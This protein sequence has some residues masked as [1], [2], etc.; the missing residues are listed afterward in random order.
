MQER[1]ITSGK[2]LLRQL[3]P[4]LARWFAATFR[5]FTDA[6][7][8]CIPWI[9][10][11]ESILLT[12]P[13]GSGKTLAA[14]LGIFDDLLRKIEG[15]TLSLGVHC[16]YVSPLRAL[17][18][19]IGK[20]L[21]A[22]IAGMNLETELRIHVRTGDTSAGERAK[23]RRRPSHFLLTTPESL[24][25]LL[26]QESYAAHLS[27]C[28]FVIVDELH[29]FAG[30]KRGVD[31]ALS[32]ERLE[33]LCRR[34]PVEGARVVPVEKGTSP[35]DS[36]TPISRF[37]Q[38]SV[39]RRERSRLCRV[40]LSATAAPL[41]LLA[42]F[43]AGD[44]RPC[45]IARAR[46]EK[47]SIVEVFSPI[48]RQPYP[49]AGYT[50]V[51]LYAEL[52]NLIRSRQ[53]VL[54]FTNV[55]S[56]AEQIGLRLKE[57]LPE[58]ADQIE[59]HHASLDRSVRLEVEDRLKN[60]EL[61]AVVCSTSLELG[62]DIGAVDLVVMVATP[63]GVSR[64][65]QRIGRSGHSLNQNSHGVLVA[66]N[67]ND[68]VEA[69]AT[70]YLVRQGALDPVKVMEKPND[71]L[72]QHI[73]GMAALAPIAVETAFALVRRAFPYRA[74]EHTEFERVLE[75]LVGGGESLRRQYSNLFG[76]IVVA[77][78]IISLAHPG[79]AREF[80]LNIGTIVS[81]GFVSVLLGRRRLG[82]VEEGF[83]KQLQLGDLFVLAGRV[84]R[85]IDT[86]VQ[87]V[88][89]ERADGQLPTIPR[90]NAAKMPLTSGLAK[91]VRKLRADLARRL[92]E[93]SDAAA[94]DWLVETYQISIANAQPIVEFFRAQMAI[95]EV[96]VGR[97]LLIEL[98]RE[99]EHSHY[100][101]HSLI[102]RS[103]NDALSRILA[104]RV[105]ERIG[106][107]ALV[108]IDDYG[109]LLTLRRFQELPLGQ[110]RDCFRRAEAEEDLRAALRGS[111]LVKWQ[112]RGVAQTGL[113]VPRNL[114]GRERKPRQLSWSSEVL[115]R[116]LEQHEPDHPLL[117][118][119]YR[120]ATHTFLDAEIA[121]AFLDEVPAF[122]WKLRELPVVSPFSFPIYASK[123]KE[124]M[125][126]EDPA[127]AI[128]RIYF[129]MYSRVEQA[130]KTRAPARNRREGLEDR[131]TRRRRRR[132]G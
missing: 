104:W 124:S 100:F 10:K 22:P 75:Y 132:R 17:T 94:I 58:L 118:E 11:R 117:E 108:T 99:S 69:I 31:L 119:A 13:T 51:R 125:M 107:N 115:F 109:F 14:F 25:V 129:E 54:V 38:R 44:D 82:S 131:M 85:L 88:H 110:W 53:S 3:H 74:L 23:F 59:T 12:S 102:G 50:G 76:K 26:A 112:F 35:K 78:G 126:L 60:G 40:G 70:A 130:T 91:A 65:V 37:A 28:R 120:Q 33:E 52:A 30:N 79:I 39:H 113:M 32:L 49:P 27:S 16:L 29:S 4:R 7:L 71:V 6:Q 41:E 111:E 2:A 62:I 84:V 97:K 87:E 98:Y 128:E 103:A 81:E 18:Y 15:G 45:R 19:D 56:A 127:T 80:L 95:S 123:I 1:A 90:W 36:A 55:R 68:L 89:V 114:P 116:V 122:E 46:V 20:N 64:A 105:R 42:K 8:R 57:L 24:A 72:A 92:D 21:R 5:D 47:E 101:F 9:L 77:Q 86:G 63:K 61:R 121:F 66:T 96:P 106:G 43:L 83:I 73:V 67:I 34:L 93:G 48:R